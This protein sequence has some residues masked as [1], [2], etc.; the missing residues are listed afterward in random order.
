VSS[1]SPKDRVSLCSFTFSD[2]R[3]C[4]T[5]RTGNH[6]HFC[7]Y[8][9]QKEARA[10]AAETLG[11]TWPISSQQLPLRL[12]SQ[13]RPG[14]P[15]PRRRLRRCKTQNRPHRRL[16]DANSHAS[17]PHVQTRIHQ[18]LRHGGL[19]PSRL[20]LRQR[21]L[22]LPLPARSQTQTARA[23]C[24]PDKSAEGAFYVP[25]ESAERFTPTSNPARPTP[26]NSRSPLTTR[27]FRKPHNRPHRRTL[28]YPPRAP[29]SLS[30]YWPVGACPNPVG[31]P[32]PCRP[33][34]TS[35]QPH[36]TLSPPKPP[37]RPPLSP[38]TPRRPA[39]PLPPRPHPLLLPP[40]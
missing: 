26:V 19:A 25:D 10:Q 14:T 36:P 11:K 12:R 24:G 2:G 20:Q 39:H 7:G 6:P 31:R 33:L 22:R 27:H 3:R 21:Q 1:L 15:H 38:T 40:R 37:K 17:H 32:V 18:R 8:H 34:R 30:R 13:H 35:N 16:P 9:A 5:P 28:L 4:R 23:F 29:N